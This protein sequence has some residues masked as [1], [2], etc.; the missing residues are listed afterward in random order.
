M[1]ASSTKNFIFSTV[2]LK[3]SV[4]SL[5]FNFQY[6]VSYILSFVITLKWA[7]FTSSISLNGVL[8]GVWLGPIPKSSFISCFDIWGLNFENFNIPLISDANI[9]FF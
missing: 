4:C 2:V 3:S 1:V 6:S 5:V 7:G 8:P 9:L